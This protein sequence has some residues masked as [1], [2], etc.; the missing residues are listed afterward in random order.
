[1]FLRFPITPVPSPSWK[2]RDEEG[3]ASERG[4]RLADVLLLTEAFG[5]RSSPRV[6]CYY[7]YYREE[8]NEKDGAAWKQEEERRCNSRLLSVFLFPLRALSAGSAQRRGA[9]ARR[10][11]VV[12]GARSWL[13]RADFPREL[14]AADKG[15]NA[16][17]RRR[18][19]LW[20]E[21]E[22]GHW[23]ARGAPPTNPCC[24]SLSSR[25]TPF[26]SS[27]V[28]VA[29]LGGVQRPLSGASAAP[30]WAHPATPRT[31]AIPAAPYI[32]FLCS[33]WLCCLVQGR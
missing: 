1:M 11:S 18:R 22:E 31:T 7:Y 28:V 16:G 12:M 19:L 13:F 25:F 10:V 8:P 29:S 2:I 23:G 33:C 9:R 27:I 30:S 5:Q 24:A 6:R 20:G 26:S 17:S 4:A 15:R 3:K 14:V 21:G 32:P